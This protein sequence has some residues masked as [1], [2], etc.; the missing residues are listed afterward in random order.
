[1]LKMQAQFRDHKLDLQKAFV[2]SDESGGGN[3]STAEFHE[4][5]RMA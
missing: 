2:A 5:L 1:M 3:I 4:W